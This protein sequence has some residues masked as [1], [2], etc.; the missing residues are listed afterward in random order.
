MNRQWGVVI[1]ILAAVG[2]C[3]AQSTAP[4]TAKV[5]TVLWA[6][7]DSLDGELMLDDIEIKG[8]VEKPGVIIL[9]KRLEPEL[10]GVELDRSFENEVKQGGAE[11]PQ[12]VK[13]LNKVD[14]V[15]SI[16]KVVGRKRK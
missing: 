8:N 16:K 13:E 14:R 10:D 7:S 3:A 2:I 12:P 6:E 11:V 1:I 15:K 4:D 9:P 5:A